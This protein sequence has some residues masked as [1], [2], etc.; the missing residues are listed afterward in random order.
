MLLLLNW[1]CGAIYSWGSGHR[2]CAVA[3]TEPE[4]Q[5]AGTVTAL[6]SSPMVTRQVAGPLGALQARMQNPPTHQVSRCHELWTSRWLERVRTVIICPITPYSSLYPPM[7]SLWADSFFQI[8]EKASLV[9]FV[10]SGQAVSSYTPSETGVC[11]AFIEHRLDACVHGMYG[12]DGSG[13]S[14]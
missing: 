8:K 4:P 11:D 1:C 5:E 10:W 9:L 2:T 12:H 13:C 3:G 14:S 6:G 7:P